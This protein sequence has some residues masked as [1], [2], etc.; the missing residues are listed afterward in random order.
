MIDLLLWIGGIY[1]LMLLAAWALPKPR[2]A[3]WLALSVVLAPAVAA[4]LWWW[5]LDGSFSFKE[6]VKLASGEQ[7]VVKRRVV[8]EV[9]WEIGGAGGW[10]AKY[11]SLEIASPR[12]PDNPPKWESKIGLIPI[13]FDRDAQT[14]QWFL[15]AT[16]YSCDAWYQLGRPKLP[17]AE[18]QLR[19][20]QWQQSPELSAK[21][22][23]LLPNVFTGMRASGEPSLLTLP[24]KDRRDKAT[25][26]P[27][28]SKF[29][30]I[31]DQWST[32]C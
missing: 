4:G 22:I 17:Y 3:K 5:N 24:E 8:S 23:G 28:D 21:Y 7:I 13:V 26:L 15:L 19:A 30:K 9:F 18:F 31:V 12:K 10:N 29:N 20:G 2:W 16:F 32:G 1:A 25:P 6:E 11:N 27:L 14:G